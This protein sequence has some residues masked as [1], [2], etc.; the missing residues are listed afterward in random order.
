MIVE[1]LFLEI[2]QYLFKTLL[3]QPS[4]TSHPTE[5]LVVEAA[6][7]LYLEK[8]LVHL[9]LALKHSIL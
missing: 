4:V 9:T 3:P 7:L 2:K 8:H 6:L 1:T 5:I